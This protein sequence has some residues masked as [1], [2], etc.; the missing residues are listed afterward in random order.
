MK[1]PLRRRIPAGLLFVAA[2]LAFSLFYLK[3]VP[4]VRPFQMILGPVLLACFLLAAA[5]LEWGVLF[6]AFGF[7]LI[8]N[9]PYFFRI[10]EDTPHAPTALVLFLALFLG[11]LAGRVLRP[12]QPLP[13]TATLRA[14][15][16]VRPLTLF[17]GVAFIS[18]VITFYRFANFFPVRSGVIYDLIVNVNG[19]RA[20]GALTSDVFTLL[21]YLIGPV[22]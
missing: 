4:L 1:T 18:A 15:P 22:L 20:G 13:A 9:L 3:Y 2:A 7:P 21:N 16:L 19:V 11:W 5:R 10:Y 12:P 14:Y 8:N 17:L 6:F